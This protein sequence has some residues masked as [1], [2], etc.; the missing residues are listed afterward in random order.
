MSLAG[1]ILSTNECHYRSVARYPVKYNVPIRKARPNPLF[2]FIDIHK[3]AG[4]HAG[5]NWPK[6]LILLY[7]KF[8]S[9]LFA[10]NRGKSSPLTVECRLNIKWF[11]TLF[12]C[13]RKTPFSRSLSSKGKVGFFPHIFHCRKSVLGKTWQESGSSTWAQV[14]KSLHSL[15]L[16]NPVAFLYSPRVI[17]STLA[18]LWRCVPLGRS[19]LWVWEE[20]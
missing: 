5:V 3:L 6:C 13:F 1:V 10:L 12:K 19:F 9:D 15:G 14:W 2:K 18:F 16:F 8:V 11:T 20:W 4:R 7:S 17:L